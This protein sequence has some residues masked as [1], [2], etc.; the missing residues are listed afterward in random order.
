MVSN[1]LNPPFP[2][3]PNSPNPPNRSDLIQL[4]GLDKVEVFAVVVIDISDDNGYDKFV[5]IKSAYVK[6]DV[7][8]AWA[9]RHNSLSDNMYYDVEP[10]RLHLSDDK[11]QMV[12][13]YQKSGKVILKTRTQNRKTEEQ[14]T[15]P[16]QLEHRESPI[17]Q[18]K[19]YVD[20]AAPHDLNYEYSVWRTLTRGEQSVEFMVRSTSQAYVTQEYPRKVEDAKR[21]IKERY[22]PN[23][24]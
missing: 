3:P 12:T 22:G 20:L 4:Y 1:P 21:Q 7:A 13:V 23:S 24:S 6:E 8:E 14:R 5:A 15:Y 11:P 17:R 16:L 9:D 18:N 10:V 19:K 2:N